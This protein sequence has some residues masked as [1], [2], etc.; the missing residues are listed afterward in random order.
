M[1]HSRPHNEVLDRP[2]ASGVAG[3][4]EVVAVV[5]LEDLGAAFDLPDHPHF[6][7]SFDLYNN[8]KLV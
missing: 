4:A 7:L 2:A 5:D 1:P 8:L 6:S 3:R